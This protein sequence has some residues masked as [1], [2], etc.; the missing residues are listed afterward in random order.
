MILLPAGVSTWSPAGQEPFSRDTANYLFHTCCTSAKG[1]CEN[2]S[3]AA[4][5]IY[6]FTRHMERDSRATSARGHTIS[7][8]SSPAVKAWD[9][10]P[11]GW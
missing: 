2:D 4:A 9:Q 8:S 6:S 3:A 7:C 1:K 5:G 10:F 11:H